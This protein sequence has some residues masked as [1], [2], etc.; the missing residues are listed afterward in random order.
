[1]RQRT[2]NPPVS[3]SNQSAALPAES[4]LGPPVG[5]EI[6]IL[7]GTGRSFVDHAGKLWSADNW[8][9]GGVAVKSA[10]ENIWRTQDPGFYRSS[11]Q[12]QFRYNIPLKK[13]MYELRLHFAETVYDAESGRTGGEGSRIMTVRANSRSLL[14]RFDIVADIGASRTAD[15]KVF[16]DIQPA[17]DGLL[18]LEFSGE[19]GTQ[20]IL[21]AIEILPGFRGHIRA[22]DTVLLE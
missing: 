7:A 19:E 6:R 9:D 10:V 14:T 5:E 8:F 17:T 16:T 22:P 18:H 3:G 2:S 11:R 20:A 21:S 1:M 12:G 15:V 4:Q 13:G